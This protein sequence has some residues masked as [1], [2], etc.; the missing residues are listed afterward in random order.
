MAVTIGLIWAH[1]KGITNF[2]CEFDLLQIVDASQDLL[3]NLS[4]I[5]K[6]IEDIKMLSLTVTEAFISHICR[7]ANRAAHRLARLS[8]TLDKCCE[9]LG[10]PPSII[11]DIL[12]EDCSSPL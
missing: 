5:G 11:L 2:L 8:L 9:W 6:I 7:Q 12:V 10:S 4:F 3:V 1:E